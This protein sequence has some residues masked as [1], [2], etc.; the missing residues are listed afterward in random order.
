MRE[1]ILIICGCIGALCVLALLADKAQKK[2]N[3]KKAAEETPME[4]VTENNPDVVTPVQSVVNAVLQ[5][6][7]AHGSDVTQWSLKTFIDFT[8]RMRRL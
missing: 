6:T 5:V 1:K 3:I 2:K 7:E 8:N 4:D